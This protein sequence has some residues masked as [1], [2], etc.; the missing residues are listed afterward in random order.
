MALN[1]ETAVDMAGEYGI[2]L[3]VYLRPLGLSV[4]ATAEKG[5]KKLVAE[6]DLLGSAVFEAPVIGSTITAGVASVTHLTEKLAGL[7]KE[8]PTIDTVR[9]VSECRTS[10]GLDQF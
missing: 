2:P 5:E 9:V 1:P 4:G 10:S 7:K 3:F 6:L 8:D